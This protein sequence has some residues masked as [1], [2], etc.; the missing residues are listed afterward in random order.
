M[1]NEVAKMAENIDNN[2]IGV[3]GKDGVISYECPHCGG[4]LQF[5]NVYTTKCEHCGIE[6]Q[7]TPPPVRLTT[8]IGQP[9]SD[10]SKGRE[11]AYPGGGGFGLFGAA[12]WLPMY[13]ALIAAFS[14]HTST[15][16]A[17]GAAHPAH[18]HGVGGFAG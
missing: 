4:P 15:Y 5:G 10:D 14:M 7:R 17:M 2:A 1:D 6:V 12:M 8:P 9:D 18:V 3:A 11:G 13:M 16:T